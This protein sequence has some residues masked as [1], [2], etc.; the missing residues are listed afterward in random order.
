MSRFML[1]CSLLVA[2][3]SAALA[4]PLGTSP[5]GSRVPPREA[6]RE[7]EADAATV[8]SWHSENPTAPSFAKPPVSSEVSDPPPAQLRIAP[9][10]AVDRGA[11]RAALIHARAVN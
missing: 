4:N 5:S 8:G 2:L 3:S 10:R 7:R 1:S 6:G 11:V 9:H